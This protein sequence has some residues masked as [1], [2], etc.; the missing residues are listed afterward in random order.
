MKMTLPWICAL[1]VA[2]LVCGCESDSTPKKD[3]RLGAHGG[4]VVSSQ[5]MSRVAPTR[6][7]PG[8]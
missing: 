4:V 7:V 8:S 5:D 3:D 1:G 6:K 2:L